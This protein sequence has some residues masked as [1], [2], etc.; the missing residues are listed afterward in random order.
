VTRIT[1]RVM[2]NL[3]GIYMRETNK[4]NEAEKLI[5]DAIKIYENVDDK[6]DP[7]L[8]HLY[9]Q[10]AYVLLE[11]KKY[12]EA[13]VM[14]EKSNNLNEKRIKTGVNDKKQFMRAKANALNGLANMYREQKN[15]I[16]ADEL[17]KQAI[18]I[19]EKNEGKNSRELIFILQ[20]FKASLVMQNKKDE[21]KNI[22][23]KILLLKNKNPD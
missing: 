19:I 4:L 6:N 13:K 5:K 1:A 2:Q 14:F 17:Y 11:K 10:N 3:A 22:N 23:K 9:N 8:L 15:F 7:T 16:K 18:M 12:N 21:V 20:N